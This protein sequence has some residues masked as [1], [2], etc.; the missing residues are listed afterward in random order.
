MLSDELMHGYQIMQ[1]MSERTGGAWHLSW[2]AI[3]RTIA[4][5]E[6][7]GLVMTREEGRPPLGHFTSVGRGRLEERSAQL[8]DLFA[9]FADAS[10]ARAHASQLA[11]RFSTAEAQP[12]F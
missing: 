5:L 1:A 4:Q 6:D 12:R 7:E 11:D 3:D 8:G 9:D 2:G 10:L